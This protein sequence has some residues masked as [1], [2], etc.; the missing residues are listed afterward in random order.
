MHD[1]AALR[2]RAEQMVAGLPPL[3][4]DRSAPPPIAPV[5]DEPDILTEAG[6]AQRFARL[7]GD[8][9]RYD[10]RCGRWLVWQGHRWAPDTDAAVTRI[11]LDF[12]RAWQQVALDIL[13]V[14]IK[15]ATMTQAMSLERRDRL[16]SML[17]LARDLRPIAD[18][19]DKWDADPW[20]KGVHNGV[21]DLRTGT[22]RPG[23]RDDRIT[24][25][26]GVAFD[27]EAVCSRWERFMSEVFGHDADLIG[28]VRRAIGYSLTGD[29]GEQCLF[30][31]YGSGSNG[32]GTLLNT[33]RITVLGDYGHALA[34]SALEHDRRPGA[35]SNEL[36]ALLGRRMVVSSEA[37]EGRRLDEGR[38]KWLTGGDPI[39]ARFL[40]AES[41]EFMP[42]CKFWLAA[43][44]KPIVG[45]DSHGFWR[46]I[47]LIPFEQSFPIDPTLAGTLAAEAPGILAWAVR[48]CLE[49]QQHGLQAPA[50]VTKATAEYR[51][52]SDVL[53][54]FADEALE[55]DHN[56]EVGAADL[57]EHYTRWADTQ[58]LSVR[59]R[60]GAQVFGRKAAE[61]WQKV[62]TSGRNV[63]I[64]IARKTV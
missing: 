27:P 23:R 36:A 31:A 17:T 42:S 4:L 12:A 38:I 2:A 53:G 26:A 39:R 9:L 20:L 25:V 48:A 46:R 7:H 61:R 51:R 63:Y 19:G 40:Y 59:E 32:K 10:H 21:I 62:K 3:D 34:F 8:D 47:R 49:W 56:S 1:K 14:K 50:I 37:S 13:D 57:Y 11:G 43:N 18:A 28:F 45:D 5:M 16:V 24:M 33:L 54:A 55:Q 64:G 58:H 41:F 15:Q 44:H 29:V 60:L 35:Q 6:A 30:F 22:L 52:D